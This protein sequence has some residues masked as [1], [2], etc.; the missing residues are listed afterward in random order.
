M[1]HVNNTIPEL[2]ANDLNLYFELGNNASANGKL[3]D[4]LKWFYKGLARAKELKDELKESEFSTL[5][6]LSL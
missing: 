3:E 6:L 4:S 1:E 2:P 5:I